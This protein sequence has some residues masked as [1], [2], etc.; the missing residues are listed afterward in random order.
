MAIA[1]ETPRRLG[2]SAFSGPASKPSGKRLLAAS[3]RIYLHRW[4]PHLA[5]SIIAQAPALLPTV[6]LLEHLRISMAGAVEPGPGET[7]LGFVLLVLTFLAAFLFILMSGAACQLVDYWLEDQP[8]SVLEAYGVAIHRLWRLALAMFAVIGVIFLSLALVGGAVT[9][10]AVRFNNQAG[11]S[12]PAAAIGFLVLL[13]GVGVV[14]SVFL[15]DALVRWAVFVQAVMIEG[16]G[17]VR[18]LSRSAELVKGRWR[19]TALI[20]AF[21]TLLPIIATLVAGTVG[22]LFISVGTNGFISDALASGLAGVMAQLT[23]SPVPAIGVTVL[24]YVLRDDDAAWS[25]ID[26]RLESDARFP[27]PV[28]P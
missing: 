23:L 2:T 14:V 5:A 8:V 10:T 15:V 22:G 1:T 21:F 13:V 19:R 16:A 17:P 28:A 9:L 7:G 24:F 18:A 26:S 20:M 11:G 12:G 25:H 6:L 4:R 27:D 3:I